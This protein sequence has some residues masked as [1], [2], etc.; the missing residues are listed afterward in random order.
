MRILRRLLFISIQ[1]ALVPFCIA[2]GICCL[3]HEV[4]EDI[5][6]STDR[7]RL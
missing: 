7:S 6:D 5:C 3:V 4:W 2:L 1:I